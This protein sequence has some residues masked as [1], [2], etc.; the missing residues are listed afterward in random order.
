GD[1]R[2]DFYI[3]N[4]AVPA[5]FLRNLGGMQFENIA[6]RAGLSVDDRSSRPVASMGADWADY[7]RDGLLDLALT[8]FQYNSFVLFRN[9]GENLF[10]GASAA[11]GL[12]AT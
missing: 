12:T 8:N 6:V 7:N 1:G 3:G 11:M 10:V 2:M 4:D 5:D 9:M